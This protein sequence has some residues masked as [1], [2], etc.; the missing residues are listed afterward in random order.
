[1]YLHR[2][3]LQS[4]KNWSISELKVIKEIN[5]NVVEKI[6]VIEKQMN[7]LQKQTDNLQEQMVKLIDICG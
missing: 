5:E 1:M 4:I 7:N 2:T 3:S 6:E